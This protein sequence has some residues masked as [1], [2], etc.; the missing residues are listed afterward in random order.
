MCA[1]FLLNIQSQP[2]SS[3]FFSSFKH[4]FI[5]FK[6]QGGYFLLVLS[7]TTWCVIVYCTTVKLWM[8]KYSHFHFPLIY[9]NLFLFFLFI[10]H[11]AKHF[12]PIFLKGTSLVISMLFSWIYNLPIL[13]MFLGHTLLAMVRA[14]LF[15][16][17]DQMYH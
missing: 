17:V 4:Y 11:Q 2:C 15:T 12:S 16:T 14:S 9:N 10:Y 13:C 1:Y 7:H 8:Q 3:G 6:I 5:Y